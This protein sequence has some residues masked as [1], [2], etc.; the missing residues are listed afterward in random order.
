MI[1]VIAK[2]TLLAQLL[3]LM[4]VVLGQSPCPTI[5]WYNR[6]PGTNETNGYVQI[7]SPTRGNPSRLNITLSH[8]VALSTYNVG[9]ELAHT[10]EE[11]IVALEQSMPIMFKL[12]FPSDLPI[13]MLTSISF[14][15]VIICTGPPAEGPIVSTI[16]INSEL[17]LSGKDGEKNLTLVSVPPVISIKKPNNQHCGEMSMADPYMVGDSLVRLGQW[18]WVVAIFIVELSY[19]FQ[20]SGTLVTNRHVITAA[21]CFYSNAMFIPAETFVIS[22][23]QY[24]LRDWRQIGS[25]N[26]EVAEYRIHPDYSHTRVSSDA[27]LAVAILGDKVE[28]SVLIRPCCLWPFTTDLNFLQGKYGTV[29]GWGL[30]ELGEFNSVRKEITAPIVSQSM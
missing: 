16:V 27:D 20:C 25:V 26:S 3:Q 30:N 29:V 24:H 5:F 7:L 19:T 28:Y 18:P 4:V 6:D 9:I 17:H 8:H 11:S 23:G 22:I 21:H 13:P 2:A 15:S 12:S 1:N 10:V 14:N